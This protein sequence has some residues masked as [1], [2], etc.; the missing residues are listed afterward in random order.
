MLERCQVVSQQRG[1]LIQAE[2]K[3]RLYIM[4][5]NLTTPVCLV[6]KMEVEEWLW[7]ARYGYLNFRLLRELGAKN[8]V[9]GMPLI[10]R[11]EQVC[12][13]CALGK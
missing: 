11:A 8:M 1:I 4:K 13:G 3:N 6:T 10:Q 9:E 2:R 12:E 5:V 7:H